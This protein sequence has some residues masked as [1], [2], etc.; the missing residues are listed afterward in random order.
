M[1]TCNQMLLVVV[2]CVGYALVVCMAQGV[3]GAKNMSGTKD[4]TRVKEGHDNK[5]GRE[6]A[7]EGVPDERGCRAGGALGCCCCLCM[8][9]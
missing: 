8:V 1:E 6:M 9:L 4:M 7:E 5:G 3:N 2:C